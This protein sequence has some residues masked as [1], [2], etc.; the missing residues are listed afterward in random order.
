MESPVF[1]SEPTVSIRNLNVRPVYSERGWGR[2]FVKEAQVESRQTAMACCPMAHY[3]ETPHSPVEQPII[4][5]KSTTLTVCC[6]E[7]KRFPWSFF[8]FFF[9]PTYISSG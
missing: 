1:Q 2:S 9:F 8:F 6:S 4:Q 3:S 5:K 7:N